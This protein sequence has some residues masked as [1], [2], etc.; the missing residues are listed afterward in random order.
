MFRVHQEPHWVL[1]GIQ[2]GQGGEVV[3][4]RGRNI[5]QCGGTRTVEGGQAWYTHHTGVVGRCVC[6]KEGVGRTLKETD[7]QLITIIK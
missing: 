7:E 1:T 2:V 6:S 5:G 4:T 3:Q